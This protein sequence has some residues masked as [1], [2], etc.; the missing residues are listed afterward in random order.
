[1]GVVLLVAVGYV[2]GQTVGAPAGGNM[3]QLL[4]LAA[5]AQPGTGTSGAGGLAAALGAS[6]GLGATLGAP[7]AGTGTAGGSAGGDTGLSGI[8]PL[9]A[10][11][12]STGSSNLGQMFLLN[13]LLR[14]GGG[15]R[16]GQMRNLMLINQYGLDNFMEYSLCNRL[17]GGRTR[18]V[19]FMGLNPM[20][21]RMLL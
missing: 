5:Q 16:G 3:A 19:G 7:G 8:L 2:S 14:G 11:T 9:M 13:S 17:M 1:M 18:G 20:C 21:M 15:G 6:G 4:A 10:M 12:G